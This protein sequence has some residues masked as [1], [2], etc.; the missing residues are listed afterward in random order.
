[1]RGTHLYMQRNKINNISSTVSKLLFMKI[2]WRESLAIYGQTAGGEPWHIF[3]FTPVCWPECLVHQL[4]EKK[5]IIFST[6]M[7]CIRFSVH[8]LNNKP[9]F[10]F[11]NNLIHF[12]ESC[13]SPFI[14]SESALNNNNFNQLVRIRIRTLAT[15]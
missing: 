6:I 12:S 3:P 8:I 11:T 15:G 4:T 7:F 14:C 1:M 9:L 13:W 5:Q 2:I 10:L